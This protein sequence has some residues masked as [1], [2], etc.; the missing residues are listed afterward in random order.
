MSINVDYLALVDRVFSRLKVPD[1]VG[2][3]LPED[4]A[5]TDGYRDQFGFI[6]LEDGTAAPFYVSLPGMLELLWDAH[7]RPESSPMR[8][9]QA[10]QGFHSLDLNQRALALGAFNALSHYVFKASQFQLPSRDKVNGFNPQAGEQVGMVGYFGPVID[11]LVEQ[12]VQVKVIERQPDRV[13]QRPLVSVST[14]PRDLNDCR[15]VYCTASTLINDSLDEILN[16]CPDCEQVDLIGPSGS[17]LP[18]VLFERGINAV[19]GIVFEDINGLREG[20]A[21]GE[22]WGK[23]GRKY[24]LQASAYPGLDTLLARID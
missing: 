22:S 8:L 23:L 21:T 14:H 20:L 12:G 11:R 2:L 13:P 15:M 4:S 16:A 24:E 19:G 9:E 7:P 1:I 10:L 6:F 18:D 3:H 17:G 5:D